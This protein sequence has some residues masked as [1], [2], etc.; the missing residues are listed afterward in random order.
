MQ[1]KTPS[2]ESDPPTSKEE[3][4]DE[5]VGAGGVTEVGGREEVVVKW[6]AG[7]VRNRAGASSFEVG[8]LLKRRCGIIISVLMYGIAGPRRE[9]SIRLGT[10]IR[11]MVPGGSENRDNVSDPRRTA[12][13]R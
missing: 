9:G 6:R 13:H 1:F 12:V 2:E 5:K 10:R 3:K 8:R 7:G 4:K 11:G